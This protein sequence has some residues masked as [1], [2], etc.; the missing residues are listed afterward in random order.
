LVAYQFGAA[1]QLEA[2]QDMRDNGETL[3]VIYHSHTNRDSMPSTT[4]H[5]LAA[6]PDAHYLIVSTRTGTAQSFVLVNGQLTE[7]PLEVLP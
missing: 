4:D 5:A 1:E 2:W 7:E 6:Y 3:M